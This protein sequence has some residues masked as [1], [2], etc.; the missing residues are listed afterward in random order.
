MV[1]ETHTAVDLG[2]LG[3]A[4]ATRVIGQGGQVHVYGVHRNNG[5]VLALKWYK[6]QCAIREQFDEIQTLVDFGPPHKRFLWPLSIAT[7]NGL[8]GFGY[9]MPLRED[10]FVELG[11]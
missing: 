8:P 4:R 5:A 7:I 10:K 3:Q 2:V 11:F 1:L 9:V 6:P